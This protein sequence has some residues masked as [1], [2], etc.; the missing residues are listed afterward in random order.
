MVRRAFNRCEALGFLSAGGNIRLAEGDPYRV[1]PRRRSTVSQLIVGGQEAEKCDM[2][3]LKL[4]LE[5]VS[6][7]D[8]VKDWLAWPHLPKVHLR[9]RSALTR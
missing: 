8:A 1:Q 6:A 5:R 7:I 2:V 9:G 4:H 3:V